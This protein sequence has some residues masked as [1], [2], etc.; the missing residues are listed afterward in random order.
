MHTF[1][2][3]VDEQIQTKKIPLWVQGL[4]QNYT[5]QLIENYYMLPEYDQEPYAHEEYH[6]LV[7]TGTLQQLIENFIL[8]SDIDLCGEH[9]SQYYILRYEQQLS[10]KHEISMFDQLKYLAGYYHLIEQNN[11]MHY[12]EHAVFDYVPWDKASS[13]SLKCT[14]ETF[15]RL[16]MQ[17]WQSIVR[18]HKQRI[19]LIPDTLQKSE[20][21][22]SYDG[23]FIWL[24]SALM[25]GRNS[26]RLASIISADGSHF[27]QYDNEHSRRILEAVAF[28][29]SNRDMLWCVLYIF[30]YHMKQDLIEMTTWYN[31]ALHTRPSY[32]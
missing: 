12:L 30:H 6:L 28:L 27:D 19:R 8:E 25:N 9:V 4:L 3:Y 23:S 24:M 13:A 10:W 20:I 14:L 1:R 11:C 15:F 2:A 16:F 7:R 21:G 5:Q 32:V 22:M 17:K 31:A 26:Q 29:Q 18:S